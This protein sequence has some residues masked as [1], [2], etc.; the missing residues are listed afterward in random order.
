MIRHYFTVLTS[1]AILFFCATTLLGQSDII[2]DIRDPGTSKI[3]IGIP[4]LVM[5]GGSGQPGIGDE[6]V[7]VVRDDLDFTGLFQ[8]FNSPPISAEPVDSSTRF[9]PLKAWLPLNV[10]S[11]VQGEYEQASGTVVFECSLFDVQ[12]QTRIVGRTYKGSVRDLRAI[13]HTFS[14]EIVYRYTGTRGVAH[15]SIAYVKQNGKNKE[16][17][18]MDYDGH[19]SYQLTHDNSIALSPDWSPDGSKIA[20]TSYRDRNPD[21]YI[22]D[23]KARNYTRASGYLGLNTTPAFS[24]DGKTLALT[25]SKDGNPELYLL[26]L[27]TGKLTRLTQNSAVD[28]S[29]S[30]SRSGQELVFVSDRSGNPQIYVVDRDGVNLRRISYSGSYNTA[31]VWSP[32]GDKIA[33]CSMVGGTNEIFTMSPTGSNVTQ[34]TSGGGNEDPSWSPDGNYLAYSSKQGGHRDICIMRADGTGTKRVASGGGDN[35]SPAWAS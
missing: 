6:F 16:I 11:V 15:T 22:I 30:W 12:S 29:P 25:L 24:P 32:K 4:P 35:M 26:T 1:V 8:I 21:I 33:Y 34:L 31:P 7:R 14:D 27:R 18:I 10:Q 5:K 20:F 2:I 13:A 17:H 19:N 28:T 9:V 23:L 3:K